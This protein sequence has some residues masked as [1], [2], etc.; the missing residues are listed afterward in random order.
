MIIGL[1]PRKIKTHCAIWRRILGK[2][3]GFRLHGGCAKK[4]PA[5]G[6]PLSRGAGGRW[7]QTGRAAMNEAEI[8]VR[9]GDTRLG[10]FLLGP[11]EYHIGSGP[12][13]HIQLDVP[14][15]A[16]SHAI[17]V[18]E[19]DALQIEDLGSET[20]TQVGGAR[21]DAPCQVRPPQSIQVGGATLDIKLVE[22]TEFITRPPQPVSVGGS[23][24]SV[25]ES[26]KGLR[27]EVGYMFNQGSMGAIH[28]ALDRNIGRNV[29]MKVI[30]GEGEPPR[31]QLLRFVREAQVMGQL[32]HPNIVPIYELGVNDQNQLFYTMKYVKGVTLEFVLRRIRRGDPDVIAEYP[33]AQLL[34]IFQKICDAVAFAHSRGIIHRDLKPE[35]IMLGEFGQVLVMDWGLAMILAQRE[36]ETDQAHPGMNAA[37]LDHQ[38]LSGTILGDIMG[39]PQFM[40]PEQAAGR[41]T[42]LDERSDVFA[43]GGIL[44]NILTLRAPLT[45]ATLHEILYKNMEGMIDPPLVFNA[46][47]KNKKRTKDGRLVPAVTLP[48]CPGNQIPDTLSNIAM[49]ALATDPDDRYQTV[50]ELQAETLQFQHGIEM[51]VTQHKGWTAA[52]VGTLTLVVVVV[53]SLFLS[54]QLQKSKLSGLSDAAPALAE[55]ARE[56]LGE[57]NLVEALSL[58]TDAVTLAPGDADIQLT[59][60]EICMSLERF[61]QAL[62]A[63]RAAA[64]I[65]PGL[66]EANDGITRAKAALG[67]ELPDGDM[68]REAGPES[69]EGGSADETGPDEQ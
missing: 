25:Q 50:R 10:R 53:F 68:E 35:N 4:I 41:N 42:E 9:H 62:E 48:H 58:A 28:G 64:E 8:I 57:G 66:V 51:L 47:T 33:L 22:D 2:E 16:A 15:V 43:L 5:I 49:K 30:L 54:G 3:C 21:L 61:E 18:F 39:T 69:N 29:A 7:N 38:K 6:V 17:L 27:Y 44:Y 55:L 67:G 59:K 40:A 24:G 11:G 34:T 12:N 14:D 31:E 56:R 23:G 60:A 36:E 19:D 46:R 32:D 26:L 63:Y 13:C 52:I 20:G 65:D 45:G 1:S 37:A